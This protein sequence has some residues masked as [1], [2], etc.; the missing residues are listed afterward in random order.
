MKVKPESKSGKLLDKT[1]FT[2]FEKLI[3]ND[4]NIRIRG[5]YE[6]MHFLSISTDENGKDKHEKERAYALKRLIRGVGSNNHTSRAGFFT[7]LVGYLE[8]VKQS[9]YCPSITEIFK[10]VKSEL[11]D[12]DKEEDDNKQNKLELRVGKVSVCGA[13]V[14]SGLIEHASDMELQ[15]VVKTLRKG[16]HKMVMPLA[17]M[18][19]SELVQK[20]DSK[21]FTKVLWP[22]VEPKVNLPKEEHT[23]DTIYFLLTASSVHKKSFKKF[24]E[25]TFDAPNLIDEGNYEYLANLLW[26]IKNTV[27]INHPLYDFLIEK[28]VKQN[29]VGVFWSR[30]VDPILVDEGTTHKFKDIVA[31]RIL[32]TILGK[33]EDYSSVPDL[34]SVAL[35]EMVMKSVKMFN[36]LSEDVRNLYQEAFECLNKCY[37]QITDEQIKLHIF[38]KLVTP[39]SSILIEKYAS[40][41][42]IQNLLVT[43]NGAS[44]KKAANI[45][46]QL[47]LAIDRPEVL[48]SERIYAAQALQKLLLNRHVVTEIEWRTNIVKFFLNL[49]LFYSSDGVKIIKSSKHYSA[50]I[51]AELVPAMKSTFFHCLEQRHT[52]LSEEKSF[53]LTIVEHVQDTLQNVGCLRVS[54]TEEHLE[55]WSRMYAVINSKKNKDKKLNDVF[56]ILLMYMG[57]H[58]FSDPELA[59]SA[60]A[61]LESVMKRLRRKKASSNMEIDQNGNNGEPEWIEVV[62]DLFLNL[63]SQNSHLLRQVIGHIFPHLSNELTL[64]AFNQILSVINLKDKTNPLTADAEVADGASIDE[65]DDDDENDEIVSDENES[66]D[67]STENESNDEEA[68][69]LSGDDEN[70]KLT[71]EMRM[72]IQAALGRANPETE[73]Q[74]ADLDSMGEEE[75]SELDKALAAAFNMYKKLKTSTK[76]EERVEPTFTNFWM[77]MFDDG[78]S[79]D[80]IDDDYVND[81]IESD[82]N[83]SDDAS[84][85]NDRKDEEA[86]QLSGDDENDKLTDE[87]RMAIQA[88]LGRANPET[89]TESADLDSMGEEEGSE[90]DKALAAAFNMYK[91]LKKT[92]TEAEERVEPT[93]N[94]FW[95]R[96]F[97]D[98]ASIDEIDDDYENDEIV[99]DENESDDASTGNESNDEEAEQFSGDDE[100]DKVTDKMRMA[101]QAALGGANPE[102]DTESVD[103]DNMGEEEGRKLDEAL[104]AAFTMYKQSKKTKSTKAEERVETTLTHFRMRVFDLIDVYLKNGP[105]MIICL[106]LMLYIFEML[107][108]AIKETKHKQILGRYRQIFNSLVKIKHFNVDIK[109][110]SAD[111]LP[112]ILTDLMEKVAKGSS[113]PEKNQYILKACQFIVICSQ[114]TEKHAE[115][116]VSANIDKVFGKY[117]NEFVAERNPAL[118]LNVFQMLFRMNWS[119]N[120]HMAKTITDNGLIK[121]IRAVRK[122]Q[123]LSLLREFVKNRRFINSDLHKTQDMLKSII[124]RLNSYMREAHSTTMSQNEFSE[125]TQLLLAILDLEKQYLDAECVSLKQIGENMQKLRKSNLSSQVMNHYLRFCKLLQLEPIKNSQHA[126]Q[127]G[128]DSKANGKSTIQSDLK[129]EEEEVSSQSDAEEKKANGGVKRKMKSNSQHQKRLKKVERLKAAS[130]GLESVS[131]MNVN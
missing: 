4:E 105:N 120:W 125:L 52:K 3:N 91:K 29:Q 65:M 28:L 67:A 12:T 96:M 73:T 88:A 74:S 93:F 43:M 111:Q 110:V 39:P 89:E 42:I 102:T 33:L 90:L 30:G 94:N 27:T 69:Q 35:L 54:L 101:I 126:L 81:E 123:S 99:S 53:L 2:F 26:D 24:F 58:L 119:G 20:I 19:L 25:N 62:V 115:Y 106:E 22:V 127:N 107:P 34:L 47:I 57:L 63:L 122:A 100:D 13:I 60:I 38:Q 36:Q 66:D 131:F 70:D 112:Q 41:K 14:S 49:G 86:E 44:V 10:L 1:V 6:L 76:A 15:T 121:E 75:G 48:N 9:Q 40:N 59:T 50:A 118:T 104:A 31:L 92:S 128:K 84:T 37:P 129:E 11:S 77:R 45:L 124:A 114:L 71:D 82:E 64:T 79:I 21:Q 17:I 72:A 32:I 68:E 117:L 78:A 7:A 95:M 83:E 103:L 5:A 55:N 130:Q 8:H 87:M 116:N 113:F 80:E 85:E 97:D 51:A 46:K 109:D 61:E 23:M 108:I 16:M 18:Y 56:H 98:G